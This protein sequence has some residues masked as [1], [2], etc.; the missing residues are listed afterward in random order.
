MGPLEAQ[1]PSYETLMKTQKN[2]TLLIFIA[3]LWGQLSAGS[4]QD[5]IQLFH[6]ESPQKKA[7]AYA[8]EE[9]K[10][11]QAS[12]NALPAPELSL[13]W[14]NRAV[15]PGMSDETM[16]YTGVIVAQELMWPGKRGSMQKAE[17]QRTQMASANYSGQI[18]Q[19]EFQIAQYY[20]EIHMAQQRLL[21]V[22]STLKTMNAILE[23]A[24]RRFETGM[25]T[26]EDLFR[27]KAEIAK[28]RTDSLDLL[29][30]ERA[31]RAML[32]ASVGV[33]SGLDLSPDIDLSD[34]AFLPSLDSLEKLA[35]SR[36][37]IHAM[38]A[39]KRMAQF[40]GKNAALQKM[41][42][43][44][45]QGKYMN[46][47]GPDEWSLMAGIKIPVAPWSSSDYQSK[48]SAAK[49]RQQASEFQTQAMRVMVIQQV[50]ES[51]ARYHTALAKLEQVKNEQVATAENASRAA[52]TAYVSGK[53]DLSMSL[54]AVRMAWMAWDE[55]LMAHM[56]VIQAILN[57]EKAAGVSPGTWIRER[58]SGAAS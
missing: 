31:M 46:M 44:M 49:A 33:A 52:F 28:L 36:P 22:D 35:A 29:G 20:L 24:Q 42:D 15:S 6:Q 26:L 23:S 58:Q 39:E 48:A 25:G 5:L 7:Y 32:Y 11:R 27:I 10:A 4:L 2:A 3:L 38:Q 53:T 50:K 57:I 34:T 51:Y 56:Q 12:A 14:G 54:D 9:A 18:L 19:S 47:M 17:A 37:E 21:I 8:V 41:P 43:L 16:Y 30:E 13:E 45:L 40:E 55:Y 1:G